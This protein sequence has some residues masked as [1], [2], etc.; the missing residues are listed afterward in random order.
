MDGVVLH[1]ELDVTDQR[2]TTGVT[3]PE[4]AGLTPREV[5][6]I[7]TNPQRTGRV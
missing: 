4:C 6:K 1:T 7:R 5:I 3:T 2:F